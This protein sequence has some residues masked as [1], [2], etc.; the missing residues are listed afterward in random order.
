MPAFSLLYPVTCWFCSDWLIA[1]FQCVVIGWRNCFD[2]VF[3]HS[4]LKTALYDILE[5]ANA[6]RLQSGAPYADLLLAHQAIFPP[7]LRDEHGEWRVSAILDTI[8]PFCI[9]AQRMPNH[10]KGTLKKQSC[11]HLSQYMIF[12]LLI[13]V[14]GTFITDANPFATT[15]K[16]VKQYLHASYAIFLP[17]H[18]VPSCSH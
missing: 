18:A 9:I 3:R 12:N 10:C 1:L 15:G 2:L 17:C 7:Q 4:K 5:W 8:H 13:L 11:F 14:F 6:K 16:K